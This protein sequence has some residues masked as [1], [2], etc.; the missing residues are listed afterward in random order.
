MGRWKWFGD[1][2]GKILVLPGYTAPF[3]GFSFSL[4]S[5]EFDGQAICRFCSLTLINPFPPKQG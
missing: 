2:E 1:K 5:L 3:K 4:S